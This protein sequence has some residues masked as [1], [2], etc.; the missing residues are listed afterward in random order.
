MQQHKV[1]KL[2]DARIGQSVNVIKEQ[3]K[4]RLRI[5]QRVDELRGK[6]LRRGQPIVH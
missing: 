3:H 5:V 2:E 4:G 1:Q 6:R